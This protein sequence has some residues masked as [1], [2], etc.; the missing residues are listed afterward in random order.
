MSVPW[1]DWLPLLGEGTLITIKI[2]LLSI[3]VALCLSALAGLG[4]TSPIIIIRIASRTYIELFRAC[5]LLVLLFWVYFALPFVGV[6]LSKLWA[7]VLAIGLNIGAYGAEIVRSAI[8]AVPKGQYEASLALNLTPTERTW[9]IIIPQA[10]ARMIPPMSNLLIE[11][12]KSTSLVYFITLS[13]LTYEA[14]I[15]RNNYYSY[16]PYIFALLLGIY[17]VLSSSISITMRIL[18]RKF[19]AWR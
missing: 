11:L 4:S 10:V 1:L 2:A 8:F 14:M 19:T 18:E 13:D 7:G 16:T 17:F 5:S 6:E 15:I 9:K 3:A 12:L